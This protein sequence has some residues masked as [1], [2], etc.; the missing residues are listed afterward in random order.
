METDHP[1]PET[2]CGLVSSQFKGSEFDKQNRVALITRVQPKARVLDWGCS[3]GYG[4][5]QFKQAGYEMVGFELARNHARFAREQLGLDVR[6][7]LS[8]LNGEEG[9]FDLI[10]TEH[11]LEHTLNLRAVLENFSKWIKPGGRLIGLVPNGAGIL[12]RKLGVSWRALIGEAHPLALTR[13]WFQRNLPDHGFS[14]LEFY[15]AHFNAR[16]FSSQNLDDEELLVIAE[17]FDSKR[18]TID[19]SF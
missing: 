18:K 12:A 17:A 9:C 2:L 14:K 4:T 16:Q 7:D 19:L 13:E 3:W 8:E 10:Y 6:S 1:S 11:V 5:Y 15:S